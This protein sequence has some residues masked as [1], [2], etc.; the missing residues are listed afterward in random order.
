MPEAARWVVELDGQ[1]R[2]RFDGMVEDEHRAGRGEVMHR[3]RLEVP[4]EDRGEPETGG[5][6]TLVGTRIVDRGQSF[7]AYHGGSE[8]RGKEQ[9]P[10]RPMAR[11]VR[12][13]RKGGRVQVLRPVPRECGLP[14]IRS[15]SI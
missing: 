12:G 9:S 13:H 14:F 11:A 3:G 15:H 6:T 7:G 5:P 8:S 10:G 4:I 2:A 1:R